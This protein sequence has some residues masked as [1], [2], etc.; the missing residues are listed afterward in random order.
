MIQIKFYEDEESA[1]NDY[2]DHT[3]LYFAEREN[4]SEYIKPSEIE[5]LSNI[6]EEYHYG[7]SQVIDE[8]NRIFNN[9]VISAQYGR[10]L[11]ASSAWF[12][13]TPNYAVFQTIMK[14]IDEKMIIYMANPP[15]FAGEK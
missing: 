12:G 14:A 1:G 8:Y 3:K 4:T 2:P 11:I 7:C 13:K 9:C 5:F 15:I 10:Y 6:A